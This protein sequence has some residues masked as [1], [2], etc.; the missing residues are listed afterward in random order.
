MERLILIVEQLEE[1]KRL[2]L[3][4]G[5][6]P[7][8]MALLLLDNAV[9]IMMYRQIKNELAV[10]RMYENMLKSM[11]ALQSHDMDVKRREQLNEHI[12]KLQEQIVPLREKRK[13]TKVFDEKLKFLT[14]KQCIGQSVAAV[15][16]SMHRYRNTAHHQDKVRKETLRPIVLLLF[17]VACDLMVS[18]RPSYMSWSSSED[19]SRFEKRYGVLAT[20]A[21]DEKQ[22]ALIRN[23]LRQDLPLEFSDLRNDLVS[24]LEA[25]LQDLIEALEFVAENVSDKEDLDGALRHIE[26]WFGR[27]KSSNRTKVSF[28]AFVPQHNMGELETWKAGTQ[29]LQHLND[30]LLLFSEFARYEAFLEP[31]E[32][33]AYEA[34]AAIDHAIDMEIDRLR[35]K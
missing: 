34:A 17:E 26:F 12:K 11:E 5:L 10:S 25:R 20:N 15:L 30:K 27:N 8:R 1:C 29:N 28:D 18:L 7:L 13:I 6:S 23:Q 14:Q 35:G 32:E 21:G 2:I 33:L 31:I 24:H 3:E 19:Y 22:R 4:G 16:S 9:E